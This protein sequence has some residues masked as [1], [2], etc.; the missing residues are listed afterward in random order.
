MH[1]SREIHW[2]AVLR[3]LTYIK[4]SPSIGLL[5][6]KHEHLWI[7]LFQIQIIQEIKEIENLFLA[8]ALMLKL[9]WLLRGVKSKI[10]SHFSAEVEYKAVAHRL[11]RWNGWN[12]GCDDAYVLWQLAAIYITSNH[13][14]H[15]RIKHIAVDC[16]FVHDAV[17]CL[18]CSLYLLRSSQICLQNCSS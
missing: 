15:E 11:V 8:T 1:M 10:L 17:Y 5:Y 4:E 2:M 18:L 12:P 14:F 3:I 9:I 13:V 6:K 7:K 16:H